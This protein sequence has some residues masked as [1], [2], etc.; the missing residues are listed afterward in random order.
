MKPALDGRHPEAVAA[1]VE[2]CERH[3]YRYRWKIGHSEQ[4][5]AMVK[6]VDPRQT[7]QS[8]RVRAWYSSTS[9][10]EMTALRQAVKYA[11]DGARRRLYLPVKR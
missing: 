5:H 1:L 3:G 8:E 2:F 11:I 6:I 4:W 7:E 10:D 9:I